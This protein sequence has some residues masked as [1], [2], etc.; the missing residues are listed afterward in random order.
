MAKKITRKEQMRRRMFAYG[1]GL[2][3]GGDF[4]VGDQWPLTRGW[5]DGYEAAR[6]D[7]R[8]ELA[9]VGTYPALRALAGNS[10]TVRIVYRFLLPIR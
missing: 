4:A 1:D 3:S 8:K 9:A 2:V 5:R 10:P 6:R 7:L